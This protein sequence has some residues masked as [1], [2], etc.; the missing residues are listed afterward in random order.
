MSS[1]GRAALL[2]LLLA[3]L[4]V[5]GGGCG[6][7]D[8][9]A[10]GG[11]E[12]SAGELQITWQKPAGKDDQT[13][14]ETL[15]ASEAEELAK[16]LVQTYELPDPL[17]V[18]GVS[19]SAQGPSYEPEENSLTLPYGFAAQVFEAVSS[20]SS[21]A[22]KQEQSERLAAVS[23][24]IVAHE[25]GHA[26]ITDLDLAAP[27][28][29]EDAADEFATILLLGQKTGARQLADASIFFAN[30]SDAQE[31]AALKHYV[32]AHGLD[33]EHALDIL[34]W[35]AGSSKRSLQEVEEIGAIG[36]ET[37]P[38]EFERLSQRTTSQLEPHLKG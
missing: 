38:Q 35:A 20:S 31:P 29:E 4:A 8:S 14:Y 7:S 3:F 6:G 13:G 26:L 24:L 28:K 32:E 19:G 15:K 36:V 34:C 21:S 23:D 1:S 33:L 5:A 25:L 37:C 17:T 11:D 16:T 2:A 18:K 9:S 10:S 22:S 12:G 27:A 30:F